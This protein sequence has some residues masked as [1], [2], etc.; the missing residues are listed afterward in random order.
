MS[1]HDAT[2]NGT[3]GSRRGGMSSPVFPVSWVLGLALTVAGTAS[4]APLQVVVVKRAGVM[5]YEEV[6]EEF[7]DRC[8]VHVRVVS[9]G[10]EGLHAERFGA[11]ELVVTVGQEALDAV[12]AHEQKAQ[13][14]VIPTL[15]FNAPPDLVGPPAS[16]HPE[17]TLK[18]LA[19]AKPGHV[20]VVGVVFGNRSAALITTAVRAAERLGLQLVAK[21]VSDG[22]DAVRGLHE[23]S[24]HVDALWLPGDSDVITPQVFQYALK[25]QLELGLPVI[26]ATRQQVHSGAL[27]AADF[28]PRASGRIAADLANRY[29]D[30]LSVDPTQLDLYSGARLTVNATVAQRLGAD[31]PA[32]SRMG[33][34]LE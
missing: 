24:A 6:A 5:A 28:S 29:L 4:A 3:S 16:P 26:A 14:R 1:G 2:G 17:L 7:G 20:H 30:G 32:L 34:R 10:D 8:R 9:F 33:A 15:A 12:R 23:L 13:A 19:L 18:L 25:L 31:L 21:R 27:M 22:P 11:N